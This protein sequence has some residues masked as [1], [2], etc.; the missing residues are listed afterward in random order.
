MGIYKLSWLSKEFVEAKEDTTPLEKFWYNLKQNPSKDSRRDLYDFMTA[1][2]MPITPNGHFIAYKKVRANYKDCH[3]GTICNRPGRVIKMLREEV[4]AD[5]THLCSSGLHAAAF[6]YANAGPMGHGI[7]LE[8]EINPRDVVA[9]PPDYKQQKM[10]VCRYRVIQEA[11]KE[12]TSLIYCREPI[13]TA[14]E[15]LGPDNEIVG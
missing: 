8:V 2:K 15:N 11:T 6:A 10:R 1:N 9:V 3:T 4:D 12:I 7:L 14:Y 13:K 5:R